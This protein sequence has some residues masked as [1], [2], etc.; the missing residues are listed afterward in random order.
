MKR[1]FRVIAVMTVVFSF[2][3]FISMAG[4][5]DTSPNS[6]HHWFYPANDDNRV[7]PNDANEDY[8]FLAQS[9]NDYIPEIKLLVSTD[10]G[11]NWSEN[12]RNLRMGQ[13]FY[14]MVESS[15][16]VPGFWLR[17]FGAKDILCTIAF[18]EDQILDLTIQDSDTSW[19]SFSLEQT[20]EQGGILNVIISS[21]VSAFSNAVAVGVGAAL[22]KS[23]IDKM[24]DA[25]YNKNLNDFLSGDNSNTFSCYSF[26]IPTSPVTDNDLARG[27]RLRL[28]SMV[29]KVDPL[30]TGSQTIKI[31]FENKVSDIYMKTYTLVVNSAEY[32]ES[33]QNHD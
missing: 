6:V 9:A 32:P 12:L 25:R 33:S 4:A 17:K 29:F 18:P 30:Q 24:R 13:S 21:T 19:A 23:V 15:V 20:V 28:V 8:M 16:R 22:M 2:V 5:G 14:L 7:N 27:V 3:F 26:S 11:E 1:R 10:N 31:F